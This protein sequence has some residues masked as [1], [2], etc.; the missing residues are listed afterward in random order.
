M[1]PAENL[2]ATPTVTFP[3]PGAP[4]DFVAILVLVNHFA[5]AVTGLSSG[6]T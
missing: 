2:G 6:P 5:Q 3:M 4:N 1:S